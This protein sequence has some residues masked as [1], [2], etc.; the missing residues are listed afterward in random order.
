MQSDSFLEHAQH[1][2]HLA[3]HGLNCHWQ[4]L[5]ARSFLDMIWIEFV[6]AFLTPR[7]EGSEGGGGRE[8]EQ[9]LGREGKGKVRTRRHWRNHRLWE[10]VR[11]EIK[12]NKSGK[13]VEPT[14]DSDR[15]RERGK[16]E[17]EHVWLFHRLI[18]M[19]GDRQENRLVALGG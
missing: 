5:V 10:W 14:R 6:Q 11:G 15:R 4:S 12:G 16:R 17:R 1:C 2:I 3:H 19:H 13:E 7:E 18:L 9:V 8:E